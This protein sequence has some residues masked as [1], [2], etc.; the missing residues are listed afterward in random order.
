MGDEVARSEQQHIGETLRQGRAFG[1]DLLV[2]K[3]IAL[4]DAEPQRFGARQRVQQPRRDAG[5][6]LMCVGH[7]VDAGERVL[8]VD[9]LEVEILARGIEIR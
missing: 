4:R 5:G 7:A 8:G 3:Q 6:Q 2:A 9:R 1:R